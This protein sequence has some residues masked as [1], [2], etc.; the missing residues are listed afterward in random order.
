MAP[1]SYSDLGK[2]ARDVFGKGYHLGVLKL[3]AKTKTST[4]VEFSN[5]VNF[6]QDSGKVYRPTRLRLGRT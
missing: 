6:N 4:G 3:D 5:E 1:P 2:Q